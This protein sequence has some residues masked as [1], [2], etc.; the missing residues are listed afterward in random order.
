MQNEALIAAA[1]A[2][3]QRGDL[4][5]ARQLAEEQL[6]KDETPPLLHH[7]MG[8]IECSA[9]R[10]ETGVGWL[11]RASEADPDNIGFRVM[12]V[13]ALVDNGRLAEALAIAPP[14]GSTPPE[15]ALWHARAEAAERAGDAEASLQSWL[16]IAS[17]H[18][19][20]WRAWCK[21]ADAAARLER[22]ADA[23][24]ALER[25]AS[26]NPKDAAIAR[27]LGAALSNMSHPEQAL[28]ALRTAVA[29][30]PD[31]AQGRLTYARLLNELGQYREAM[32][33]IAEGSRL[34]LDRALSNEGER[35]TGGTSR[36]DA[37]ISIS[38]DH[39]GDLRELGL[40]LD[41]S[42]QSDGLRRLL[43][44]AEK[45]GI[46][47]ESL[48]YLGASLALREGRPEEA[49]RLLMQD[50]ENIDGALWSR[51]MT[52]IADA[53]GEADEAFAA[54][55]EMNRAAPAYGEW[56][57]RGANYRVQIRAIAQQVT[58]EWASSIHP[59]GPDDGVPAPAFLVGFP[60]SGT[61]LLDTFLMGHPQACVLEELSML[62]KAAEVIGDAHVQ[63]PV[64]LLIRSRK[65]YVDELSRHV[66]SS[67]T[68]LV[69]DKHPLNMLRLTVIHGLFPG[70]KIIFTQ[71][72]PCD[73][74]LSGYMQ[75]FALNHA[76]ASFL[77]L[78]DAADFY[79]A[80]MTLWTRS[81]DAVPQAIHTVV[82]ERLTADPGAEL[83]PAF[84]F[85]GLDWRDELLD[86]QSTAKSR[87]SI[88][89]ASFDQVV[90][91]LNRA[92]SG[93][94]RR[95]RKQ[96]EPVL[97]ILLPWAERLGYGAD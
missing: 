46:A 72:H 56:R 5:R 3:F 52:R 39:I 26:L 70:A 61:T 37:G 11:R 48:G 90:Q 71:R 20:D 73:V 60:R 85:L 2:A 13:R 65:A 54:A 93:R 96:L 4:G 44:A 66:R 35:A 76:M 31:N 49:R 36:A 22:W 19:S 32:A 80:A 28:A 74:V 89:T 84:D 92:P 68:G 14:R 55:G 7:L 17:A 34:A 69:V 87:G 75:N 40:L 79:D 6:A 81:R 62:E 38:P 15:L 45:A 21:T 58:P 63:W 83:R 9:G 27:N 47:A 78:A 23:A 30:D 91:P 88:I 41:R 53:L 77:D 8:L 86:H 97:P 94:W 42:N 33:Q 1:V 43:T 10:L 29:L 50:R 64:G 18:Q 24:A 82:Y 25:A 67:F 51:L 95:Y 12:L 57:R 16:A 59:L